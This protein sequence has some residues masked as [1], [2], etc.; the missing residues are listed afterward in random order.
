MLLFDSRTIQTASPGLD[1]A[2][3]ASAS[4]ELLH[5]E[6]YVT[7]SPKVS[8]WPTTVILLCPPL[9]PME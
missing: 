2:D 3:P 7:M 9:L 6:V 1:G 8:T 5:A 4:T